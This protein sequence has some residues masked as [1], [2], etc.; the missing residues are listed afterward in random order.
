MNFKDS[1]QIKSII[2]SVK[3]DDFDCDEIENPFLVLS[4][5]IEKLKESYS[6]GDLLIFIQNMKIINNILETVDKDFTEILKDTEFYKIFEEILF[7]NDDSTFITISFKVLRNCMLVNPIFTDIFLADGVLQKIYEIVKPPLSYSIASALEV[8]MCIIYDHN[9][10]ANEV[11][12]N[13]TLDTILDLLHSIG[14]GLIKMTNKISRT[15]AK[16]V[17]FFLKHTNP[18][19]NEI[20]GKVIEIFRFVLSLEFEGTD[21]IID[22]LLYMLQNEVYSIDSFFDDSLNESINNVLSSKN[23]DDIESISN[24]YHFLIEHNL[25]IDKLPL[26]EFLSTIS[27]IIDVPSKANLINCLNHFISK[28]DKENTDVLNIFIESNAIQIIAS[29]L[30]ED[31]SSDK[32]NE[33]EEDRNESFIESKE[34]V[35]FQLLK[36]VTFFLVS[37]L[38]KLDTE[39]LSNLINDELVHALIEGLNIDKKR[40]SL[41]ELFSSIVDIFIMHGNL[42]PFIEFFEQNDGHSILSSIEPIDEDEEL[43]L[44]AFIQKLNPSET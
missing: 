40:C 22:S 1:P 25:N 28:I 16:Y 29:L 30:N 8:L 23:A 31:Q 21:I 3:D 44:E 35:S 9:E 12:E 11:L 37:Y 5:S 41:L 32:Q 13:I 15:V 39:R 43:A 27:T 19:P 33:E 24:L 10:L 2:E 34:N 20:I 14:S 6:N 7:T 42:Q 4:D 38:S 36:E 26:N 17:N 18:I